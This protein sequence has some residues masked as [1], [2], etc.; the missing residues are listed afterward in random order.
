MNKIVKNTERNII[1]YKETVILSKVTIYRNY[2]RLPF[3]DQMTQDQKRNLESELLRFIAKRRK[4]PPLFSVKNLSDDDKIMYI[5]RG[6]FDTETSNKD[7][8]AMILSDE[9][10]IILNNINHINIVNAVEGFG[11]KNCYK[12]AKETEVK[13]GE[14]DKYLLSA[15]YGYMSPDLKLCGLGVKYSVLVHLSGIG[16]AINHKEIISRLYERGYEIKGWNPGLNG[17]YYF[18]ISTRLN[19]GISETELLTRFETGIKEIIDMDRILLKEIAQNNVDIDDLIYRSIGILKYAKKIGHEESLFHLSNLRTGLE[20]G[21]DIEYNIEQINN[22]HN[23]LTG[24][25]VEKIA[26]KYN[27]IKT[28]GTDEH[29]QILNPNKYFE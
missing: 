13:L 23:A 16:R 1:K 7:D 26:D 20:L 9:T 8:V 29:S 27:L 3:A 18:E 28:G 12:R 25:N 11:L 15:R 19:Y 14:Y 17:T 4:H 2:S 24:T 5:S 6:Y 22:I 21:Y 10:A